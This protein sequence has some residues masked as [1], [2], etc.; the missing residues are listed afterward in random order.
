MP[1]VLDEFIITLGL[2]PKDFDSAQRES[3]EKLRGFESRAAEASSRIEQAMRSG[4]AGF[5]QEF[6]KGLNTSGDKLDHVGDRSRRTGE[7]IYAAGDAGSVGFKHLTT[8]LLEAYAVVGTLEGAFHKL[9]QSASRATATTVLAMNIGTTPRELSA[10]AGMFPLVPQAQAE[11]SL[12]KLQQFWQLWQAGSPPTGQMT[13]LARYAGLAHVGMG[14]PPK[15]YHE[16]LLKIREIYRSLAP[17]MRLQFLQSQG[18]PIG[19]GPEFLKSD[20]QFKRDYEASKART[21]LNSVYQ[22]ETELTEQTKKTEQAWNSLW[23]TVEATVSKEGGKKALQELEHGLSDVNTWIGTTE[24]GAETLNTTLGVLATIFGVTLVTAIGKML[25]AINSVWA[26]PLIKFMVANPAVAGAVAFLTA[27]KPTPAGN[28]AEVEAETKLG[29]ESYWMAQH[30]GQPLPANFNWKSYQPGAGGAG[31]GVAPTGGDPRGLVPLIRATAAKYGIDP[32]VAVRVARSEGLGNPV[33][34]NNTSFGA[35]QLHTGGGLGDRFQSETGLN[36]A[37]PRNEPATIDF[38]MK[39]LAETGWAP[40]HGAARVGISDWEGIHTPS[41]AT[42]A[43]PADHGGGQMRPGHAPPGVKFSHPSWRPEGAPYA[44]SLEH[45][46]P[47]EKARV[48]ASMK[49]IKED[50]WWWVAPGPNESSVPPPKPH[51]ALVTPSASMF[52]KN[53]GAGSS[54]AGNSTFNIGDIT[55]HTQA[56]DADGISR[57]VRGAIHRELASLSS[58]RVMQSNT[59]YE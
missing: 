50:K 1:T 8:S 34:D 44:A 38:A 12:A 21:P 41:P 48:R 3:M 15:E 39:H 20:A 33:G 7:K 59:I 36:P 37:D 9:E 54:S 52:A 58:A 40:Y 5:Y 24:G 13:E 22:A 25:V 6:N 45:M 23:E 10:V 14:G 57:H 30:P 51:A 53:A 18:M 11:Q 49:A 47:E 31:A 19:M 4:M 32:D 55:I 35:F 29:R 27:M 17:A 42:S 46:T 28:D 26:S 16:F 2:D 43:A 56:T